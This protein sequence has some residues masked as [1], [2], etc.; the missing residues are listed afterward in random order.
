[1]PAM[2]NTLKYV[3]I[4][5]EI[6]MAI[7]KALRLRPMLDSFSRVCLRR[8]GL[9]AVHFH[10]LRSGQ[11]E[12]VLDGHSDNGTLEHFLS[13]PQNSPVPQPADFSADDEGALTCAYWK[14]EDAEGSQH[15]Y[16]F[17]LGGFGVLTL[18]RIDSAFEASIVELLKPLVVRLALSCQASIEHENLLQVVA[19]RDKA[20]KTIRFQ[21][22][23]D[24]LTQLPNRRS[25]MHQLDEQLHVAL[26]ETGFGAL[27]FL[28]LDRFKVVNDTLGHAVGDCL[29]IAVAVRLQKLLGTTGSVFRLS[30]DEFVILLGELG[31]QPNIARERVDLLLQR[32]RIG[33]SDPMPAGDH[34]LHVTPSIGIEMF[35]DED[36][37]AEQIL[38]RA[39]SAMYQA[40]LHGLNSAV[41]YDRKLSSELERRRDI[42]KELQQALKAQDQFELH[43]QTQH[44]LVGTCIGAEALVRWRNPPRK[45]IGPCEFI[46]IAEEAGLMLELGTWVLRQAC[47][48]LRELTRRQLPR[49]FRRLSVNV[50]AVQFNHRHFVDTLIGI[51][52]ETGVDPHQL[53]IELTESTLI[54]NSEAAI[55]KMAALH[56]LGIK[57]A[58]DDFG[59]GF[60]S[61]SYLSRLP[62]QSIKIDQSFVRNIDSD[63]GNRAIVETIVA[64]GR[65]LG[66]DL[67]AE[68]VETEAERAT[69]ERLGCLSY[70]G[71]L[72]SRPV[73]LAVMIAALLPP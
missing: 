9:A 12:L 10:F 31:T 65:A 42:E 6:G 72:F 25:L 46:P 62:A 52:D 44:D 29:L 13:N 56:V 70:Q 14:V 32:I 48:D 60:S 26:R 63:G 51:I 21:L 15:Y 8:L 35:P 71:F 39:D 54:A 41:Y 64:L 40:K 18:Q 28:D 69:L 68:G 45:G 17:N 67:I 2:N 33:F 20:E 50:S 73:P 1:M 19:A 53:S 58:I 61:L 34:Q 57:V 22:L 27:L 4:Q 5:H 16:A 11:G 24:D 59:T 36:C 66:I 43:Y 30:G 23:H 37:S 49:G 7:G 38:R 3:S 47:L 55:G